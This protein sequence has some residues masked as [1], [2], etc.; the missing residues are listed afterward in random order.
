MC[1]R[2]TSSSSASSTT[3]SGRRGLGSTGSSG[4]W[5]SSTTRSTSS[6]R[7][8]SSSTRTGRPSSASPWPTSP[9]PETGGRRS[10]SPS[11][12]TASG[13]FRVATDACARGSWWIPIWSSTRAGRRSG[14][15]TSR[16]A[17]A[18]ASGCWTSASPYSTARAGSRPSGPFYA[19]FST[20]PAHRYAIPTRGS[21]SSF[22]RPPWRRT[23]RRSASSE[24]M[25]RSLPSPSCSSSRPFIAPEPRTRRPPGT[26]S[27][28]RRTMPPSSS[29]ANTP[30]TRCSSRPWTSACSANGTATT[31]VGGRPTSSRTTSFSPPVSRSTTSR[32]P[33]L[34]PPS[35]PTPTTAAGR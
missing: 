35:W 8:T 11:R 7:A 18:T 4:G 31:G 1:A 2:R 5:R 23:T 29:A 28:K 10:S 21:Q 22:P 20:R 30:S 6:T 33:R 16:P 9:S 17:T 15:W 27:G 13:R 25:P 32:A 3:G 24:W 14:T 26:R 12:G 19:R 34:P